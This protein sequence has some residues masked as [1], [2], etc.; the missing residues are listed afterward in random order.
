MPVTQRIKLHKH[1]KRIKLIQCCDVL[2]F[3]NAVNQ[4]PNEEN[5]K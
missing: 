3:S 4:R 1:V 2:Q 5:D